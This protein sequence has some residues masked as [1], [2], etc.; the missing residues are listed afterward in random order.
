[1]ISAAVRAAWETAYRNADYRVQL[2][3][4]ELLLKINRHHA[5]DDLRLH[6]EAGIRS[7]W[8]IVTPCNPGSLAQSTALNQ[9]RCEELSGMLQALAVPCFKS[10]NRDSQG[11]WPDE[12]GFLLCDPPPG[13]AEN[14]GRHF[15]QNAI[16]RGN[17]GEVSRLQWLID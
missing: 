6:K 11:Q 3:L 7:H 15:E 5:D 17:L 1:M 12:P 16:L 4:G 10:I 13:L 2:P 14:L 8:A 9:A